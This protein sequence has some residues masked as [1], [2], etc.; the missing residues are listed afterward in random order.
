MN[1]DLPKDWKVVKLGSVCKTATG[2]TPKRNNPKYYK[3]KIPWVKSGELNYDTILDTEEKIT[4]EAVEDSNAKL[5]PKG[6]ILI[7]LYGATIGRLAILG[8]DATT[9]QAIC[10]IFKSA[11]LESK[12]LFHFLFS[13]KQFLVKQSFGGAQPNISQTILRNLEIPIPPLLE[14]HRIVAKIEELFSD[15][16]KGIE[17]LKTAQQQLKTYRQSVL[18]WAFEGRLTNKVVKDGA[19]PGGWIHTNLGKLKEFSM[20]GPRYSSD[21]YVED[22]V[23]VLRTSDIDE[24]GK[25]DWLNAPKLNLTTQEYERYKL[26]QDDLLITRTGSIGTV[27]IFNDNK[28]AIAGAFLIYYRLKKPIDIWYIFYFL[29][30]QKAQNH[31]KQSS[32]GVGR[33]NLNVP[34]IEMLKIPLPGLDEQKKIVEE[35]ESRLSVCDKLEDT[36]TASLQQSESLR[37]SILKKAFEGRLA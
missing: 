1:S 32:A 25:V 23:A 18:K 24:R 8:I 17:N 29:N 15:L 22:G 3:G 7:A 36:I 14:Q 37:Q 30:S 10:A 31:L 6:S 34:K 13:K 28:K 2:G 33:P 27:S 16:D 9:N 5:F 35:I 11:A 12:F 19:L 21:D 20:Y 26:I 4:K